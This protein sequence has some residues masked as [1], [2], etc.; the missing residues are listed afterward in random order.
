MSPPVSIRVVV[1]DD[2]ALMRSVL[3]V[4]LRQAAIEVVGVAADGDEALARCQELAPDVLS[5]DLAMPGRDGVSVLR[6]LRARGIEI[7]V[8]V[9][10]AFSAAAGAHAVEALAEGA[11]DLVAKPTSREEIDAF[12]RALVERIL[13]AGTEG[14]RLLASSGTRDRSDQLAR[15]DARL[16]RSSS[17][18]HHRVVLIACSTGGP[19]ALAELLPQLPARLGEGT[20]VVQHMPQGFTASLA[21]R[22]D[23]ASALTVSEAAVDER[24]DP[25]HVLLAPGGKHMRLRQGGLIDLTDE[26]AIGGLR[27]RADVTIQDAVAVWGER[28]LLVVLTGMGRD[29]LD[30]AAAVRRSG[31]RTIVEAPSSCVVDGMPRAVMAAGLADAEVELG[32]LAQAILSEAGS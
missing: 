5:L 17:T 23:R 26:P 2:S 25:A 13:L 21:D 6:E 30:G 12:A 16:A 19:R 7:P 31:G 18:G 4:Y 27:P 10:S 14:R 3:S 20:L 22:L 32:S 9:V 29:G 24:L 28:V 15:V 8:V 11:F 1:A